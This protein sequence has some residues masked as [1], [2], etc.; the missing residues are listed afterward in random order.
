MWRILSSNATAVY[1]Q[2]PPPSG[3]YGCRGAEDAPG[4]QATT[5]CIS[6]SRASERLPGD[7]KQRRLFLVVAGQSLIRRRQ[8]DQLA[9]PVQLAGKHHPG[10]RSA[11]GESIGYGDGRVAGQAHDRI[12]AG[13]R[14]ITFATSA[15]TARRRR[16]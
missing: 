1:W 16:F 12:Q 7:G 8:C 9:L 5:I 11:G 13:R 2:A 6:G 15:M 14:V 3:A 10:R 4:G